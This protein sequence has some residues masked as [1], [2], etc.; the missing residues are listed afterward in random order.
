MAAFGDSVSPDVSNGTCYSAENT[1]ADGKYIPCGNV[2]LGHWPCCHAGDV[3]L[4]FDD[5]NAC[6]DAD[7]KFFLAVN[8]S[9]VFSS[10]ADCSPAQNTYIAG[11]TDSGFNDRSCPRKSTQFNTQQWV[12]IQHCD[13]GT[14]NNDTKWGGCK[15]DSDQVELTVLPHQS[16]DPY[17]SSYIYEGSSAL[18]A[19]A[20]LPNSTGS[21][22]TWTNGFNPT[23]VYSPVTITADATTLGTG[24]TSAISRTTGT[25]PASTSTQDAV[26]DTA[27][28]LSV[29]A[30]AGIG[31]GAA[32]AGLLIV[33]VILLGVLV[34][35][36]KRK[37]NQSQPD[38]PLTPPA[39]TTQKPGPW[40]P[41]EQ[42]AGFK[43]E[44]P[45]DDATHLQRSVIKSE[46]PADESTLAPSH[47]S[48]FPS[49]H[50]S[51]A[52]PASPYGTYDPST[53]GVSTL[54]D[55]STRFNSPQ[56]T[57]NS[58]YHG[59][60]AGRNQGPMAPISELQG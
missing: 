37:A 25:G 15:V 52:S 32:V 60:L 59:A 46:L 20:T 57:G 14:G 23:K 5:A 41:V 27:D 7:C 12:A 40:P 3:C 26:A 50:S 6:Y 36:R 19:F 53:D 47:L 43:S 28:G 8:A 9:I 24:G 56:S 49:P 29:G 42:Y 1:Q 54:S 35:R 55:G 51:T 10:A 45:A 38:S 39:P 21:S 13:T 16:C 58:S 44:L 17:C 11:C 48:P 2:A 34:R 18:P 4:S 30:K 31:V 33:A 22:I